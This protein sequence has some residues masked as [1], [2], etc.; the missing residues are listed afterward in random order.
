MLTAFPQADHSKSPEE[1]CLKKCPLIKGK[2][3]KKCASNCS[4]ET[5]NQ[6]RQVRVFVLTFV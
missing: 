6:K 2:V 4:H 5:G 3:D 1:L